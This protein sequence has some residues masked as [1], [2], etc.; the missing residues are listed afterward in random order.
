MDPRVDQ[1]LEEWFGELDADGKASPG[2]VT[3]WFE[4]DPRFDEHLRV[5]YGDS[6]RAALAGGLSEWESEPRP[7]LA[8]ILLLDQFTRNV[9]RGTGEMYAGDERAL[10][11]AQRAVDAGHDAQLPWCFRPFVYLPFMHAES[12]DAQRACVALFEKLVEIAPEPHRSGF[13]NNHRYA[14]AHRDIVARFG[15]FPHRNALLGRQSSAAE[16]EFLEQPGSSF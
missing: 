8:L 16:L 12:L 3:R 4:K 10:N 5:S 6:I 14:M 7:T 13:E 11:I 15:R 1:I 2:K 9:F